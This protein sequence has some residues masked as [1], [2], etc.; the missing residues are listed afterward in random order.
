ML[1]EAVGI[2]RRL[3]TGEPVTHYGTHYV[4]EDARLFDVPDRPPP[5]LVSAFGPKATQVAAEIGDGLWQVGAASET[6]ERFHAAGGTGPIWTQ[7]TLCWDPDRDAAVKRA[8][9]Q[10]PNTLV[11]GQL[12]Q[13]LRT[14]SHFEQLAASATPDQIAEAVPCGPD[15]RPV[16]E[17]ARA[18]IGGGA[19]HIYFHQIGDPTAGFIDAWRDELRPQLAG[20]AR[21]TDNERS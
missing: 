7:L 1:S 8:H 12:S 9:R 14:V 6:I 11:P 17:Q 15:L 13:D 18:A 2:V 20:R 5:I 10:W 21:S 16:L 19:D 4:V 3:L